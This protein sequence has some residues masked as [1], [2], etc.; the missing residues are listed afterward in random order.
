[1]IYLF[2]CGLLTLVG[3]AEPETVDSSVQVEA[4]AD[5]SALQEEQGRFINYTLKTSGKDIQDIE[6]RAIVTIPENQIEEG[7]VKQ[8]LPSVQQIENV[9]TN[10]DTMERSSAADLPDEW[11]LSADKDSGM[12]YRM[13]YLVQPDAHMGFFQ[14]AEVKDA[15]DYPY[16][17]E[18]C[19]D[20]S[21]AQEMQNLTDE[22]IGL[23][24]KFGMNVRLSDRYIT[25]E[26]NRYMAM[27]ETISVLD[28]VPIVW[29]NGIFATN[30]CFL[31]EDG[32]SSM[33]FTGKFTKE[34][35]Q[36]VTVISIDQLLHNL[37]EKAESGEIQ[38]SEPITDIILAYYVD[39]DTW[40]F[41]PIW[42]LYGE[43]N[44][45]QIGINAQTG[46]TVKYKELIR[47]VG[48]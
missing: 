44:S 30:T 12:A 41:F 46:E 19:S 1:M 37:E 32:V 5:K 11:F 13:H 26:E 4:T 31:S 3:C 16:S 28:G 42:C 39:Y 33:S 17:D 7:I 45:V 24:Q 25:A 2:L 14:N 36:N 34:N 10:G 47:G 27:V 18:N 15:A 35:T 21:M 29:N 48:E 22:A 9:F 43:S 20:E 8:E 6:I 40:K 23:Y 38:A